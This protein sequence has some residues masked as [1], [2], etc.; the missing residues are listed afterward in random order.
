[1]VVEATGSAEGFGM[2]LNLVKPRGR[3]VLKSTVAER[4]EVD[5]AAIVIDEIHVIGSR[6]GPFGSALKMLST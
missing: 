2:A 6:C 1:M 3:V 5:L 4:R